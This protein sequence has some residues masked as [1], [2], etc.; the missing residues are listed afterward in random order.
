[1]RNLER[2]GRWIAPMRQNEKTIEGFGSH[3]RHSHRSGKE[4][5]GVKSEIVSAVGVGLPVD[6]QTKRDSR[7][8][9]Q[10]GTF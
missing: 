9:Q 2:K 7:G 4:E 1:M 6:Y 10:M 3:E 8:R 5:K